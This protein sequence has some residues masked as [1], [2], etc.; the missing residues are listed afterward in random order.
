MP[1]IKQHRI[2]RQDLRNNPSVIYVFGDNEERVGTGGQAAEMRG[3]PNAFGIPTKKTPGHNPED[4]WSEED[5]SRQ[6]EI[7]EQ[8]FQWLLNLL[9]QGRTVVWPSDG[10]GT[11]LSNWHQNF[12]SGIAY[13]ENIISAVEDWYPA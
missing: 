9:H 12:P 1:F 8:H 11:G 13:I 7:L 6:L 3:E 2:Y 10:I 4:Y 5:I